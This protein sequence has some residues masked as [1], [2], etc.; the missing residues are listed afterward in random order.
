M[1]YKSAHDTEQARA[2]KGASA[3][4]RSR[5]VTIFG[6]KPVLEALSLSEVQFSSLRLD[7]HAQGPLIDEI[8]QRARARGVVVERVPLATVHKISRNAKQ[9]QGV[10]LDLVAPHMNDL[11]NFLATELPDDSAPDLIVLAGVTNPINLGMILR[12]VTAAD[13][14]GVVVPRNHTPEIAAMV[15]KA[16]AG[17]ALKAPILRTESAAIAMQQLKRVGYRCIGL[18]GEAKTSLFR[19]RLP[20]RVAF[21]LGNE[22]EG[23]PLEVRRQLDD[24]LS[25]P[26]RSDVESL[27]VAVTAGI[28]AYE[29]LRRR[30]D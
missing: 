11:E 26:M 10:V 25:L 19:A 20:K 5:F 2:A 29:L 21:V 8:V 23:L 15:V 4:P 16:S 30:D 9:D 18:A 1:K 17:V 12:S 6:R 3:H 27:N 22:S 24:V 7:A 13:I 28:L 14:G